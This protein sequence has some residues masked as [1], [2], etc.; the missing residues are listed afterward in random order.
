MAVRKV[1]VGYSAEATI[2]NTAVTVNNT[3]NIGS[4]PTT[5]NQIVAAMV[6]L[7]FAS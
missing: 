2:A 5:V 7:G 1:R 6:A 4:L 3:T